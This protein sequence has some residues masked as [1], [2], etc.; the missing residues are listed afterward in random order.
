MR[1]DLRDEE[2]GHDQVLDALLRWPGHAREKGKAYECCLGANCCW[3]KDKCRRCYEEVADV[4][5]VD[6][7]GLWEKWTA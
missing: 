6:S 3:E 5:L 4:L 2:N 1:S 7:V